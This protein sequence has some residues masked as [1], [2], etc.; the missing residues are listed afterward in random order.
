M[1]FA[2]KLSYFIS[3]VKFTEYT[4]IKVPLKLESEG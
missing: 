2:D 1:T 3:S 4:G